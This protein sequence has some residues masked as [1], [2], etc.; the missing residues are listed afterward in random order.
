M[1]I[2]LI[3]LIPT[4][5]SYKIFSTCLTSQISKS[6]PKNELGSIFGISGS[7]ASL[8]RAISPYLGALIVTNY[9]TFSGSI[10]ISLIAFS[11]FSVMIVAPIRQ[12]VTTTN[13]PKEDI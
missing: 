3:A 8:C 2:V 11:L 5:A 12:Q 1:P 10:L 7:L 6:A 13:H 9:G 4:S